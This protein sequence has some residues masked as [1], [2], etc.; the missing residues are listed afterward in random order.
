M[1][2]KVAID[3]RAGALARALSPL[4]RPETLAVLD[5]DWDGGYILF[6]HN[7]GV[8]FQRNLADVGLGDVAPDLLVGELGVGSAS[9][10]RSRRRCRGGAGCCCWM[11]RR[12]R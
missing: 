7:G 1:Q 9:L 11:S 6:V 3:T 5:L 2:S 12:R 4:N 8:L 10:W